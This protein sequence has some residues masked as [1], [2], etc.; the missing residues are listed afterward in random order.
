M[1]QRRSA[2]S[3]RPTGTD[4]S[5][6]NYRMVVDSRYQKVADGKSRLYALTLTQAFL[7]LIGVLYTYIFT[8][9]E[10]VLNVIAISSTAIG[11]ISLIL[12]DIG[13]R[14]SRV[15]LLKVHMVASSIA[16]LLS[17]ACV[18]KGNIILKVL[19]TPSRWELHKFKLLE[20]A[21]AAVGFLVQIFTVGTIISLISNMSP[22]KR[23][24]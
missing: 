22:P 7:L 10:E 17:I 8:F 9:H 23:T 18:T 12:G 1:Q 16:V 15:T 21:H 20:A 5:D 13:R 4:G 14:R 6:F 24:S 19:Q 11:F 3:G 2:L